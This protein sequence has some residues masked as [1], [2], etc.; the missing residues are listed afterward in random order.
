M[1]T[2]FHW[3]LILGSLVAFAG[4]LVLLLK[5]DQLRAADERAGRIGPK[6]PTPE[7]QRRLAMLLTGIGAAGRVR[8]A[9]ILIF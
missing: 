2:F 5:G 1:E 3:M 8:G 7:A 4:G 6:Y 9:L